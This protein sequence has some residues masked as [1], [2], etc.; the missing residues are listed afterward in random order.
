MPRPEVSER[1]IGAI[2]QLAADDPGTDV[3]KLAASDEHGL[4]VGDWPI[5]FRRDAAARQDRDPGCAP[6]WTRLRALS[7]SHVFA[8]RPTIT[9][10]RGARLSD[11]DASNGGMIVRL[12]LIASTQA[13]EGV[14]ARVEDLAD[15]DT[16]AVAIRADHPELD[17]ALREGKDEL[18]VDGEPMSIRLHLTMHQVLA[19]QLAEDDPPEVYLTAQRLLAAGYDRHEVLHMLAAPIAEQIHATLHDGE[20]YNLDWH[21]A[22]LAALPGSWE[23]QRTQRT[24]KR[25]DPRGRHTARRRRRR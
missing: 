7:R 14:G 6:A 24:L 23:R 11:M 21:L 1:V 5:R 18:I 10:G 4:R 8:R 19:N 3:R 15:P 17:R 12:S 2:E 9:A 25:E 20:E 13:L 22:A 16:R